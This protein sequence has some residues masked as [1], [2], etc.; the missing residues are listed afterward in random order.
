MSDAEKAQNWLRELKVVV[1]RLESEDYRNP[2]YEEAIDNVLRLT[3][4]E[5]IRNA[6]GVVNVVV[7]QEVV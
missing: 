1:E 7:A 2:S 3:K 5:Y 4:T 6:L